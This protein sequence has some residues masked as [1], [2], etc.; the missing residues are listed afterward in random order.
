MMGDDGNSLCFLSAQRQ[1]PRCGR[2]VDVAA[3]TDYTS[4]AGHL[5]VFSTEAQSLQN[6][7]IH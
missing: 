4:A 3:D 2:T 5:S 6:I 1:R 7:P